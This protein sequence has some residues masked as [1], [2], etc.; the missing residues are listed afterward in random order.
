MEIL[1]R[2]KEL[3]EKKGYNQTSFSDAIGISQSTIATYFAKNRYPKYDTLH[4]ILVTFT[5]VSAEWLMR[6]EGE[7]FISDR[8][9]ALQGNETEGEEDL[10]VLLAK[11]EAELEDLKQE[12]IRLLGQLEFMEEYNMKVVRRM[13]KA[14]KELEQLRGDSEKK[15]IG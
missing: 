8:L 7:M 12:H 1:Q 4:A 15:D 13:G 14:E 11:R 6:G 2:I 10:H 3:I 9:P 5:D